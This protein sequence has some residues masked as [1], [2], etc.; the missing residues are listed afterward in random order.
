MVKIMVYIVKRKIM[1]TII[2]VILICTCLVGVSAAIL[3]ETVKT[4]A[5]SNYI[6]WVDFDIPYTILKQ[7]LKYDIESFGSDIKLNWIELLAYAAA[8]GGGKF[9]G[10]KPSTSINNMVKRLKKGESVAEITRDVKYYSF[11]YEAYTAILGEYVGEYAAEADD[12]DN[13]GQTKLITKY[14]LKVFSPIAKGYSY[15]HSDDF[16]NSRSYGYRRVHLGNDL[17]GLT[18]TPVIAVE[19]GVI[20]ALGWNRYGGWRIGIRSHDRKRYY[21]YAHLRK[22][23]PFVK[24]LKTGDTVKAGDVIGYLGRTGYSTKED[25]NNLTASHLHFGVQLIFDESQKEGVNQIWINLY[26]IVKLLSSNRSAV[27]KDQENKD[28]H[29]VR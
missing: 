12:P 1:F 22:G 9:A 17:F 11:Y 2:T 25:T 14:G 16:G 13:P 5:Q 26:D 18:G 19:G 8:R 27:V 28:Y 4:V 24:T 3:G 23:H 10:G 15:S 7:A 6:K 21:Y 20:E 29:R